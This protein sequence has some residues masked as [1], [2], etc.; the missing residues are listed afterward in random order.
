MYLYGIKSYLNRIKTYLR[1][2]SYIKEL[3]QNK[4][5]PTGIHS[6]KRF[7]LSGLLLIIVGILRVGTATP[8]PNEYGRCSF[9][10]FFCKSL[11]HFP[12][13]CKIRFKWNR[14]SHDLF[15]EPYYYSWATYT[16]TEEGPDLIRVRSKSYE[17]QPRLHYFGADLI[18]TVTA[19]RCGNLM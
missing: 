18:H 14:V 19:Y 3:R 4:K 12:Y 9:R 8:N 13:L 2:N 1:E 17:F 11:Q 16:M 10:Q 7:C 15:V 6:I 5:A